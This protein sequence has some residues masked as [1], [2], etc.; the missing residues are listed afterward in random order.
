MSDKWWN[1]KWKKQ[2]KRKEANCVTFSGHIII[3]DS[4]KKNKNRLKKKFNVLLACQKTNK[5]REKHK[6]QQITR[7][8]RQQTFPLYLRWDISS[9]WRITNVPFTYERASAVCPIHYLRCMQS[10][11]ANSVMF[12]T[13]GNQG[14]RNRCKTER[15][16]CQGERNE[17]RQ[18]DEK[19]KHVNVKRSEVGTEKKLRGGKILLLVGEN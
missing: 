11:G 8:N 16:V 19:Q 7:K 2:W 15:S 18:K 12:W 6:E 14:K 13:A 17:D 9:A 5:W 1:S 4:R 10:G 3:K